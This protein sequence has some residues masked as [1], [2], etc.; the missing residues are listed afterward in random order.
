ML[1]NMND[2]FPTMAERRPV[3]AFMRDLG[4]RLRPRLDTEWS[5]YIQKQIWTETLLK[6][7]SSP[8]ILCFIVENAT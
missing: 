8:P 1:N 5:E 2:V 4:P 7:W 3:E 6:A